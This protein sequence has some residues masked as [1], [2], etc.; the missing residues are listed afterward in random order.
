MALFGLGSIKYN[1][2]QSSLFACFSG[3]RLLS[4]WKCVSYLTNPGY[5]EA[6]ESHWPRQKKG[7][8]RIR[9]LISEHTG[10]RIV[11]REASISI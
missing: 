7:L 9:N 11:V 6:N 8:I 10:Y 5:S 4:V 3:C 1:L 2:S